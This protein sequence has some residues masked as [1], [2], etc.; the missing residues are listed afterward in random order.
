M[1]RPTTFVNVY[2]GAWY[3]LHTLAFCNVKSDPEDTAER[4]KRIY[5]RRKHLVVHTKGSKLHTA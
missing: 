3:F 5:E 1:N 4:V 2:N